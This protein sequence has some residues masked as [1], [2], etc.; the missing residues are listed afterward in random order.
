MDNNTDEEVLEKIS[1]KELTAMYSCIYG[2]KRSGL[3][4]RKIVSAFREMYYSVKRA[5]ALLR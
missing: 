3:T 5:E 2:E 1:L 4:K